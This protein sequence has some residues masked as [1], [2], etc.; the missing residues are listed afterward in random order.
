M[1][2]SIFGSFLRDDFGPASDVDFLVEFEPGQTPSLMRMAGLESDLSGLIGRKAD[3][4]TP[5]ELSRRF[6]AKALGMTLHCSDL[7]QS[8]LDP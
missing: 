1:R 8:R 4:R 2:L 7:I 3:L 5:A 6:R